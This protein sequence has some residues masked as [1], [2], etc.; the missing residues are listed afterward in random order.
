VDLPSTGDLILPGTDQPAISVAVTTNAIYFDN[1]QVSETE[2]SNRLSAA[3]QKTSGPL[4]L[5]VQA[6]KD[7]SHEQMVHLEE[8]AV[9]AG[10]TNLVDATLP[11]LFDSPGESSP[12]PSAPQRQQSEP[13]KERAYPDIRYVCG[14]ECG[15][16]YFWFSPRRWE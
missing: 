8:L 16:L 7:L 14:P 15:W 1:H 12:H 11:R 6:D 10:I 2:L 5:I 4:T 3:R 13:L 9:H